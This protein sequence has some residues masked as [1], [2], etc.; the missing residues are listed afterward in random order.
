M[1]PQQRKLFEEPKA[2]NFEEVGARYPIRLTITLYAEN[3]GAMESAA[4][5]VA[6][7]L[8]AKRHYKQETEDGPQV[9]HG[10]SSIGGDWGMKMVR[11]P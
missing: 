10:G 6:L 8:R 9:A 1:T 7:M 2:D 3:W 11:E 5:E 4:D